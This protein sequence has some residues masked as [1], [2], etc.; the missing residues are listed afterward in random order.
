MRQLGSLDADVFLTSYWQKK[1]LLIRAAFPEFKTPQYYPLY[2]EHLIA[3]ACEETIPSRLILNNPHALQPEKIW[4]VEHGPFTMK[5]FSKL[6][7]KTHWSLLVGDLEK[8]EQRLR[9]FLQSFRFIPDWRI[10]DLMISYAPPGGSVGPHVDEYDVFLLQTSGKKIWKIDTHPDIPV[11]IEGLELKILQHFTPNEEWILEPGDM[12]YLPPGIPHHG[13]AAQD[14]QDC[15]TWSIGFRAPTQLELMTSLT[16]YLFEHQND[17]RYQDKELS[18]Q[19]HPAEITRET[20][21]KIKRLLQT[22]VPTDAN[23]LGIWFGRYITEPQYDFLFEQSN[24]IL[25]PEATVEH[26]QLHPAVRVAYHTDKSTH[27]S[28]LFV[29]G[30]AFPVKTDLAQQLCLHRGLNSDQLK[31]LLTDQE[32]LQLITILYNAGYL[33]SVP[34]PGN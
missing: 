29:H 16:D 11:L 9:E 34:F 22:T 2:R 8:H 27:K 24:T 5:D 7:Q 17:P 6:G 14:I 25:N 12:L 20:L 15:I 10:D 18:L 1:P 31:K 19:M 3:Y 30:E 23:E 4:R 28:T 13:I 21:E 26:L 33:R 32:N